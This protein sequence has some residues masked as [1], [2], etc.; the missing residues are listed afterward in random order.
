MREVVCDER[1]WLCLARSEQ[2][3]LGKTQLMRGK[4]QAQQNMRVEIKKKSRLKWYASIEAPRPMVF[5]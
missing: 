4:E 2:L 5:T 3:R 1:Q